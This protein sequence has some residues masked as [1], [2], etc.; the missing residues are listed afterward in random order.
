MTRRALFAFGTVFF[1]AA[2][3]AAYGSPDQ[4]ESVRALRS[5]PRALP[6]GAKKI[7]ARE[8]PPPVLQH[9]SPRYLVQRGDVLSL[10]FPFTPEFNDTVT[11]QPDGYIGLRGVGDIYVEGK[12]LPELNE[13]LRAAYAKI[14]HDPVITVSLKDFEKPYFIAFGEVEKPGKYELR[15]ETTL[16]QG[17]AMAGGFTEKSKHSQVLLFRRVSND[18][19]EVKKF[20]L[21]H[22]L[23]AANL[24]EDLQLRPGDMLFVPKNTVSKVLQFVP[25]AYVFRLDPASF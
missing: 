3:G 12:T 13:S 16:T 5:S 8:A 20:N 9:R 22:M 19:A 24:Q 14:L 10:D 4:Q 7:E 11:V 18:W 23:R 6:E 25:F 1:L 21:K 15:G 2:F 17:V